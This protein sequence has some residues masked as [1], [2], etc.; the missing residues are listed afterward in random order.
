MTKRTTDGDIAYEDGNKTG[1][2]YAGEFKLSTS[3]AEW[4]N[5]GNSI[6]DGKTSAEL[7]ALVTKESGEGNV[8]IDIPQIPLG[9]HAL[10]IVDMT[11]T[12]ALIWQYCITNGAGVQTGQIMAVTNGTTINTDTYLVT[13]GS[14]S[15]CSATYEISN[16]FLYFNVT[17]TNDDFEIQIVRNVIRDDETAEQGT[18]ISTNKTITVDGTNGDDRWGDGT[19]GNPYKTIERALEYLEFKHIKEGVTVTI[20]IK[21]GVYIQ[22]DY[23]EV[24]HP[25]GERIVFQG[26][27]ASTSM[28]AVESTSGTKGT[29]SMT[30]TVTSTTG[31]SVGEIL[32]ISSA[33]G[34][35]NP[36]YVEGAFEITTVDDS[37]SVTVSY[38]SYGTDLP[39]GSISATV[40]HLK[41]VFDFA[42]GGQI[43]VRPGYHSGIWKDI[44]FTNNNK[45][46]QAVWMDGNGT[47]EFGQNTA[48]INFQVAVYARFN[49]FVLAPSIQ[50][51]GCTYGM[52]PLDSTI[53]M[54]GSNNSRL[55]GCS[56]GIVNSLNSNFTFKGITYGCQLYNI[57]CA[58]H[59]ILDMEDGKSYNSDSVGVYLDG[60]C[61]ANAKN[62]TSSENDTY[63][64]QV[65]ERSYIW[66]NG[67][68]ATN[69]PTAN[70]SPAQNTRGNAYTYNDA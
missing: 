43:R 23:I 30:I 54:N 7:L 44:G 9:T 32:I 6:G 65:G 17:C 1:S 37:D 27:T 15:G 29:R 22:G 47:I 66:T 2:T 12:Q 5:L 20:D 34:G 13:E 4:D 46:S 48:I 58:S 25:D 11:G 51:S 39:S 59:S 14:I 50:V 19:S 61:G 33:S 8:F 36:T 62:S 31:M 60:A 18:D 10:D 69:N 63:G 41:T 53:I 38:P 26:Q 55:V 45:G 56:W 28:T 49:S 68:T 64:F 67:A 57:Y 52:Y 16:G 40:T 42:T 35:T 24:K 70:F 21:D 3:T